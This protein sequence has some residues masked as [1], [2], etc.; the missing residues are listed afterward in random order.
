MT[1]EVEAVTFSYAGADAAALRSVSLDVPSGSHVIVLGP[2]GSGKSTLLRVM[3]GRLRPQEGHVVFRG[4]PIERWRPEDLAREVGVVPQEEP[5][6]FP[7]TVR[8]YVAMGRYPHLGR[9]RPLQAT[10]RRAVRDALSR[11][12]VA[13]LADRPIDAVSG[14]E[15][16]RIRVSRALAQ[17]AGVLVLDEP[18]IHLDIRHEMGV[19]ELLHRL[20]A[21]GMTIVTVT[22]SLDLAGQYADGLVLLDAGR[23]A[24]AGLARD[25]LRREILEPVYRWPIAIDWGADDAGPTVRPLKEG[26]DG[27]ADAGESSGSGRRH[28]IT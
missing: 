13:E 7:M 22:H 19:F 20:V 16:Q 5:P 1:F 10:D 17:E 6:P 27:P 9:W 25:V 4:R 21:E 11:C 8:D 24:A 12:D 15:R 28:G 26:P 23:V 14:G 3:L 18:T 2:N